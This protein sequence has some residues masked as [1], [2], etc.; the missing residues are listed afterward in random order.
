MRKWMLLFGLLLVVLTVAQAPVT[1][2]RGR[3]DCSPPPCAF[4]IPDAR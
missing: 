1:H 4:Q 2:E 3:E